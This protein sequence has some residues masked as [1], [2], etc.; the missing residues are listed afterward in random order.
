METVLGVSMAPT[1][2]GMVLVEGENADG[3][4]VD[5]DHFDL[6][7]GDGST[8]LSPPDQVI[9]AIMGTRE[10]AV[11]AGCHLSSAGVTW[12]T[13]A[14]GAALRDALADRK[15]ENVMLV[16]S[17]MAAAALAHAVGNATGYTQTALLFVE[18]DAATLAVVNTAD[19]SIDDVHRMALPQ[20]DDE[21]VAALAQMLSTIEALETQPDGVFVVGSGVDIPMIK[22]ALDAATSLSV[23]TPEEPELAL[24]RGA[25]LASANAPLFA[26]S[27]AALA[28]ALDPGTGEVDPYA[29]NSGF[30]EIPAA[31][32]DPQAGEQQL[33]YSALMPASGA[34]TA[35][36]ADDNGGYG[37]VD[38]D[39][40]FTTGMFPD[41]GVEPVGQRSRQPFLTAISV[42]TIFVVGV[43]ALVLSLAVVIRPHVAQRPS[44]SQNLVAPP[45]QA[46]S[47]PQAQVP[48]PPT[49]APA[50]AQVPAAAPLR[51]PAPVRAAA[52]A[53]APAPA[54]VP[55]PAPVFI[56]PVAPL[57]VVP[58]IIPQI[59][60][61]LP[62]PGPAM[63]PRGGGGWGHG[64]PGIGIPHGGFGGGHGGF[65]GGHGHR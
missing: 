37:Q 24:A 25:A 59:P 17:F 16:S 53:P 29:V 57:P 10:G 28:Y 33:A 64:G 11:E 50:P 14:E 43:V 15:V 9:A 21:A 35:A 58:Q 39:E 8:T 7:K 40:D 36:A 31:L 1:A 22:P 4:T 42:M 56:P 48:A 6:V 55:A 18:P 26:S 41:F 3:P 51:P 12:N 20:D 23:T 60:P 62:A 32:A 47:A 13:S 38:D 27:T 34:Y 5:Q 65:G 30:L 49:P 52:P 45:K 54:L 46:P 44:L 2:V 63:G 19:G 61:L